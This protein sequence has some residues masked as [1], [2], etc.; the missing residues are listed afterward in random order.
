MVLVPTVSVQSMSTSE[1]RTRID[2]F[3]R[4]LSTMPFIISAER[5]LGVAKVHLAGYGVVALILLFLIFNNVYAG[6]LTDLVGY[7]LPAYWSLRAVGGSQDEQGQW[8]GYWVIFGLLHL[9]EY[10][11][12][13]LL[14]IFPYYYTFKLLL[15][16]WLIL[17]ATRGALVVYLAVLKSVVPFID[18]TFIRTTKVEVTTVGGVDGRAAAATT[19]V[20]EKKEEEVVVDKAGRSDGKVRWGYVKLK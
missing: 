2:E 8:L 12:E 19:T 3:D 17:P 7:I 6:L 4:A 10:G 13:T 14:N 16:L 5:K 9:F 11:E 20:V 18:T 1:L 15:L